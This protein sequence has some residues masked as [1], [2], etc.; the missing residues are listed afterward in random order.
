[1]SHCAKRASLLIAVLAAAGLLVPSYAS[2]GDITPSEFRFDAESGDDLTSPPPPII[3]S[4]EIRDR[5]IGPTVLCTGETWAAECDEY[6]WIVLSVTAEDPDAARPSNVGVE[7]TFTD[8]TMTFDDAGVR[9]L[10]NGLLSYHWVDGRQDIQ[11]PVDFELVAYA[12]DAAGNRSEA[13]APVRVTDPGRTEERPCID[14]TTG[15]PG[16]DSANEGCSVGRVRGNIGMPLV[17][18]AAVFVVRRRRR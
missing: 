1:M 15:E 2:G 4:A 11:E 14:P 12:Y 16:G 9:P 7:V 17:I 18:V 6:G 10:G 5:G 8:E 13:S 3:E